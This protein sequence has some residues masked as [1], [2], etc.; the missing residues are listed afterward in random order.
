VHPGYGVRHPGLERVLAGTE[1][2][3]SL[4]TVWGDGTLPLRVTAFLGPADLPS[5]LVTSVRCFVRVRDQIVVCETPNGTW[6]PWPGGRREPRES[7]EETA[8]REVHEETGWQID[9]ETIQFIGWLH[10]EHLNPPP[11]DYPYPHPDFLQAVIVALST[12]REGG[13][14]EIGPIP[15]AM[16]CALDWSPSTKLAFSPRRPICRRPRSST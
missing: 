11:L 5:E 16:R 6:H 15:R 3:G 8:C 13:N 10:L 1:P 7:Y 4:A 9:P 14:M 2:A 12:F